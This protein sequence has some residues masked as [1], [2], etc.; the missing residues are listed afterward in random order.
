MNI[1]AQLSFDYK[2]TL[3]Q[4]GYTTIYTINAL[5]K[6]ELQFQ[7]VNFRDGKMLVEVLLD[8]DE[9]NAPRN[10]MEA[11]E[12][13][14]K[15]VQKVEMDCT[16]LIMSGTEYLDESERYEPKMTVETQLRR[17]EV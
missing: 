5:E 11:E 15:E 13:I 6:C 7:C 1:F 9:V 2:G 4:R 8:T 3:T 16:I 14:L 10:E 12:E 17:N